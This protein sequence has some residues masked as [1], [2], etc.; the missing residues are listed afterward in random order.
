VLV[1]GA[2]VVGALR[3]SSVASFLVAVVASQLL[4]PVLWDHYAMLLL[5]PV[6]WLLDRGRW[7]AALI[8]LATSI[9][10]V[11]ITPPAAYPVLFWIALLAVLWLGIRDRTTGGMPRTA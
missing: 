4:S 5:L 2:V 1:L 8:P 3:A 6:A 11:P 10:V 7:W 9:V